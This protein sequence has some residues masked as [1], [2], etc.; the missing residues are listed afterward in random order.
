[1]EFEI[2]PIEIRV[3]GCMIEKETTTPDTYPMTLNALTNATNQKSNRDP[4]LSL[5]ETEVITALDSLRR[6]QFALLATSEGSRVPKFRHFFKEKFQL[7]PK[8]LAL[9]A[10]LFLRG[11]QTLGE[12]RTR[13]SRMVDFSDLS[14]V[15]DT[16]QSLQDRQPPLVTQLPRVPGQKECRYAQLFGGEPQI[17]AASPEQKD[18]AGSAERIERLEKE[19]ETLRQEVTELRGVV[20]EFRQLME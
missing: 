5:T 12:L 4:V 17:N 19:L 10:E 16:L 2:N 8:Q 11:P 9:I 13:A 20:E 3:A 1:M 15:E 7:D 18:V 6:K 14:Q